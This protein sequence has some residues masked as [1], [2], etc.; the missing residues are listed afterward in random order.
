MP[1]SFLSVALAILELNVKRLAYYNLLLLF[2]DYCLHTL[3]RV[4]LVG[5]T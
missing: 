4:S 5:K 2:H 3:D 1:H